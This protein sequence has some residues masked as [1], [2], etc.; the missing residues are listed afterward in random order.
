MILL[1]VKILTFHPG[2]MLVIPGL[3]LVGIKIVFGVQ[4]LRYLVV[5][6]VDIIALLRVVRC[7][8]VMP[9][10]IDRDWLLGL[11]HI[12]LLLVGVRVVARFFSPRLALARKRGP[13]VMRLLVLR[14]VGRH[15]L[16]LVI[17]LV[18]KLRC[19]HD[20]P[21]QSRIPV[22]LVV[23]YIYVFLLGRVGIVWLIIVLVSIRGDS[24]APAISVHWVSNSSLTTRVGVWEA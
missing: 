19:G 20:W 22:V 17:I 16:P 23:V 1:W 3:L 10:K 12:A 7:I 14:R 8:V 2:V 13:V 6:L 15:A 9:V 5:V 24:V 18:L 11:L 4:V 21:S